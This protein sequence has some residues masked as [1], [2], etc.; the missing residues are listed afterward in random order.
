MLTSS[1]AHYSSMSIANALFA[2][3]MLHNLFNI[4]VSFDYGKSEFYSIL[5]GHSGVNDQVVSV[6]E[7]S[8]YYIGKSQIR[9]QQI[10]SPSA[11]NIDV[12]PLI[13]KPII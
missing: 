4:A 7:Y 9:N 1:E 12:V 11:T 8:L 3:Y 13:S 2:Y 5:L 10:L 6:T